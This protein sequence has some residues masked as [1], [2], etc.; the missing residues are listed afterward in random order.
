MLKLVIALFYIKL[1]FWYIMKPVN[2]IFVW[3]SKRLLCLT[4][5]PVRTRGSVF[6]WMFSLKTEQNSRGKKSVHF[7]VIGLCFLSKGILT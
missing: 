1:K 4:P 2:T 5:A 6:W 7:Y 3:K